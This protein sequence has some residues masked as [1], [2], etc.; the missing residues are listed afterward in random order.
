MKNPWWSH[1]QTCNAFSSV[2]R[3]VEIHAQPLPHADFA[4][5]SFSGHGETC[6]IAPLIDIGPH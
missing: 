3:P 5:R 1:A 4:E 6:S 2:T